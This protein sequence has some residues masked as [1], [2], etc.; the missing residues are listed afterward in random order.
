MAVAVVVPQT[1]ANGVVVVDA[2][3]IWNDSVS[4]VEPA[5][6]DS[7]PVE[8]G[9]KFQSSRDGW[10]TSIRYY[11]TSQARGSTNGTLWSATGQVLA[12]AA[13]TSKDGSGWKSAPLAIPVKIKANT[14]YVASYTAPSG[15][16]AG[17][18]NALIA[19]AAKVTRDLTATAGVYSYALGFPSSTW[20]NSNYFADITFTSNDPAAAAPSVSSTPRTTA[21]T[22]TPRTTTTT[23]RTTTTTTPRT[24]APTTTTTPRTTAPTTTTTPRTTTATTPPAATTGFPNASNTGYKVAPGYPGTLSTCSL[25]IKSNTTYKF[26]NFPSGLGVGAANSRVS[27]VTFI[28]CRFASNAKTDANVAIYGNN[29]TFDYSSF[30][31]SA[32][33]KAPVA[34]AQGYQYGIDVRGAGKITID[35]SDFWGWGNGIQFGQSTQAQPLV[36]R[37]TWFHDARSDG[38]GVDHTD[39]ILSNEGG[40]SYMVFDHNTIASVGNTQGLALQ[41]ESR[42]YDHVTITNNYFS[43]FGYTVAI[44][45]TIPS[46]NITFTGN[47]F[48]TDFKPVW[49]P[50]YSSTNWSSSGNHWRNNKWRVVAGSYYTPTSDDGKYFLPNGSKSSVDY[51]G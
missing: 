19:S 3:S 42:G 16:Y 27:N 39:A 8:L 6:S 34:Y 15:R 36:I 21:P 49:G 40:P 47:V 35:H 14:A 24:T 18:Q 50:L 12:R 43:G 10:I 38:G 33:S 1:A 32:V 13:F 29:I 30:E 4:P 45:E 7:S 20:G 11:K 44:G 46:T 2:Y 37:N 26:C 17:D 48:G 23:P 31:P 51:T 25:P 28:G 22:T 41:T 5:D 9:V